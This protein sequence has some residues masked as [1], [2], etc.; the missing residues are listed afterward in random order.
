MKD[1][2]SQDRKDFISKYQQVYL[3]VS[4]DEK[5]E[6]KAKGAKWDSNTKTWYTY[7]GN[8]DLQDYM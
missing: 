3:D 8:V 2:D 7:I 6:V 5:D 4:Y 1:D